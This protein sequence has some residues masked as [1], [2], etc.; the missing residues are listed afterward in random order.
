MYGFIDFLTDR[1]SG[2]KRLEALATRMGDTIEHR[3]QDDTGASVDLKA[4]VA[5]RFRRLPTIDR[6]PAG[7]QPMVS[8]GARFNIAFNAGAYNYL[9]LWAELLGNRRNHT[10]NLWAAVMFQAWLQQQ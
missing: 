2:L 4:G 10:T 5:L 1:A 8:S 7:H 6:L 9:G 3:G